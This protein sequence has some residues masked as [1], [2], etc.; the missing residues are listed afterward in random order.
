[1]TLVSQSRRAAALLTLAVAAAAPAIAAPSNVALLPS[2]GARLLANQRFDIRVEGQGAGPYSAKLW[3]DGRLAKFTSGAQGTATTDGISA[4]GWG[5]F[6]L[7]GTSLGHK[8]WHTLTAEFTDGTGT[9]TVT[10]RIQVVD[11]F[12]GA[13][14]H[15]RLTKNIVIM[16]GDGMG[17]AHRTAARIVRY[18]V[19]AGDPNGRLEMDQFPGTGLV[20]THSL[21]SII[22]DSA[23]GMACYTTGNH[24]FNGQEGVYPAHVTN[25]F[26][27]PRVEYLAEYLHRVKGTALG[28]VSTADVE[29]ATPAANAVHTANRNNGTGVVDQYLDESDP[30]NSRAFG[31]GLRVLLGGG[32]RWFMPATTLY[33]SRTDSTG[34]PSL[35]ADLI[36]GWNLPATP[37]KQGSASRDLINDFKTAGFS[38]ASSHTELDALTSGHA[39]QKLLGLFGYGNMNVALDKVAKRRGE[40]PAG[41]S[42]YVVDDYL[43]PDQPM[44]DEMAE[45]AFKVLS[46]HRDGFVLMIE[47]AHIDKQSHLMDADRAIGETLEFDRAVGVARKWA[48]RLGD[49]TVLVL[50]DHECSG[51]SLIGALSLNGG[52]AALKNLP[53]ENGTLSPGTVPAH[54]NAVGTYDLAGFPSYK[55]L[56]DG[57]PATMDID[58]KVLVG[59][60]ANSDRYESWLS[61]PTPVIDSL[62]PSPF[63]GTTGL[64]GAKGYATIPELRDVDKNGFFIRGHLNGEGQAVHTAADIPVSAYSTG[65]KAWLRFVGAQKNTDVF[66]KLM[67]AA[68]AGDEP[69]EREW[70][71]RD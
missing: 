43:A 67:K 53:S 52:I 35:P 69:A 13:R 46:H 40:L 58:N 64:L 31:T 2:D 4:A 27:A 62:L 14:G 9:T 59:F 50:A 24:F 17:V 39:P 22:T 21:N 70:E 60:G 7:R 56:P 32:R 37:A 44:L 61:K 38:Y 8:G 20:S 55:I 28:L 30:G 45:A 10:S 19:T 23:P 68:L 15:R 51:F 34:Y 48:D 16:L 41:A 49:T 66:F 36:A 25:P 6:N 3:I 29:D 42:S 11:P 5:G 26:Y 57:Y 33:S 65:N 54:Q 1:M 71:E 63:K 47:G 12:E 18:G